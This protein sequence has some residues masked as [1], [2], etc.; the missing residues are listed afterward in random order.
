[1]EKCNLAPTC[2]VRATTDG[3]CFADRTCGLYMPPF[4]T[5]ARPGSGICTTAATHPTLGM[6]NR[7]LSQHLRLWCERF[8]C[9]QLPLLVTSNILIIRYVSSPFNT[10]IALPI[11]L[12]CT[13]ACSPFA[14]AWADSLAALAISRN[15]SYSKSLRK[16]KTSRYAVNHNAR[17]HRCAVSRML[18]PTVRLGLSTSPAKDHRPPI[19]FVSTYHIENCYVFLSPSVHTTAGAPETHFIPTSAL[20]DHMRY[21][22]RSVSRK[23]AANK[24]S[25]AVWCNVLVWNITF[26]VGQPPTQIAFAV[27]SLESFLLKLCMA[28]R[29]G[30]ERFAEISQYL[31]THVR[32]HELHSSTDDLSCGHVEEKGLRKGEIVKQAK[33]YL[34][35][36]YQLRTLNQG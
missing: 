23:N 14:H 7:I 33:A 25:V 22:L 16:A 20:A 5:T 32:L 18:T 36:P 30:S 21:I 29:S 34:A 11:K 4:G 13:A 31:R 3:P 10:T 35:A 19:L 6:C 1:M 8:R 28:S 2:M 12:D 15:V 9:E 24:E 17:A 27:L 26:S